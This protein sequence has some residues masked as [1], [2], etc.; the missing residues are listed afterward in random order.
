MPALVTLDG[1]SYRTSD[2]RGLFDGLTL[3]SGPERTGLVGRNGA[4]KST[5]LRLILGELSPFAGGVSVSGRV[6]AVRQAL[7][8]PPGATVADFMGVADGLARLARIEAGRAEEDDLAD[9]DWTLPIRLEAALA[10]VGLGG[11]LLS[12]P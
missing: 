6:A 10:D 12:A 7:A 11:L 9:A 5:L 4:G 3:A 8:P 1:L 2:G